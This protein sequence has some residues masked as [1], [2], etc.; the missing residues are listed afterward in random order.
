MLPV[1]TEHTRPLS[2]QQISDSF[3][4]QACGRRP[5][6]GGH[7]WQEPQSGEKPMLCGLECTRSLQDVGGDQSW[8]APAD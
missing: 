5:D 1:L 2:L 8:L 7:L 4:A 3:H 6:G